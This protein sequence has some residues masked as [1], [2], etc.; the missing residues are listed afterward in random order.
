M[1]VT[2]LKQAI[3]PVPSDNAEDNHDFCASGPSQDTGSV[4]STAGDE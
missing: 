2:N 1:T 3:L 4:H